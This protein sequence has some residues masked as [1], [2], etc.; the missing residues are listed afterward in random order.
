MRVIGRRQR[1]SRLILRF[2]DDDNDQ[3]H[4]ISF[5][6]ENS[7]YFLSGMSSGNLR[8]YS[9]YGKKELTLAYNSKDRLTLA[10]KGGLTTTSVKLYKDG[11]LYHTFGD[12][13]VVFINET[14]VYQAIA[15]D[16]YYSNEVTVTAVTETEAQL[17][18]STRTCFLL[19]KDGKV[20]YW[21][22][23][24]SGS[25][26]M[27]NNTT[28]NVPTLHDNLNAL[29]S[30]IKQIGSRTDSYPKCAITN[31]G[32]LYTWGYNTDGALGRGNESDY[33]SQGPWLVSTQSSNTF[34]RCGVGYY[35]N[36]ALQDNGYLWSCGNNSRYELGD[37]TNTDRNTFIRVDLANVIDFQGEHNGCIA[38]TSTS[39]VYM[40]GTQGE[41]YMSDLG[42][43]A[44]PTELTSLIGKNIVKVRS[45]ANTGYA[46]SS[47]GK[48]YAWGNG[49][50]YELPSGTTDDITT[51]TEMTWFSRNNVKVVDVV[52][53][54]GPNTAYLALDDQDRMYV[55]GQDGNGTIGD[56]SGDVTSYSVPF[57]LKENIS[58]M[59][60][61][62]H[63][64]GC[65]DKFG[66]V[67]TW[68]QANAGQQNWIYGADSDTNIELPTS[69]NLSVGSSVVYDG[70]DK[71]VFGKGSTTTSNVTYGSNT[72]SLGTNSEVF[73]AE[74]HT[75]KFKIMDTDSVTYTSNV[76]ST[77]PA[78]PTGRVYPPKS[79]T[80]KDLSLTASAN[81]DNTWTIDGALYG[82]GAYKASMSQTA[83]H[84]NQ[85]PY[86][87]FTGTIDYSSAHTQNNVQT[88]DFQIHMP[89][90]IKLTKYAI[91]SRNYTG[92]KDQAPKDWKVYG[93][94]DNGTTWTELDSQT[95]QTVTTW[96]DELDFLDTKREYT[97]TGNTKYFSS[98]KFDVTA[99]NGN[100]YL[101]ISQIEY[102]GD[103]EGFLT[104]DGFGKLTLD[105]KGDTNATSN[106]TFHSNTYV[107][108]AA[109]DLYIKDTGE[110]SANIYGSS[111]A[112]LGEKVYT[113][114]TQDLA[115]KFTAAFHHG[116]FSA[117]D[118]S[119][120]YSSVGRQQQRRVS[121]IPIHPRG[122]IRGER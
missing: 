3:G 80:H 120:A 54:N 71:Y 2:N 101:V 6:G 7:E 104:D 38:V 29:P 69:N 14:G 105:V 22:D 94:N 25:N 11:T 112:F 61:G 10:Y 115:P 53:G 33:T 113:V 103:D 85:C 87:A 55:W 24:S 47:D 82:N 76:V 21:G 58:S 92:D 88:S 65:I 30:G 91:Y 67:Y 15:D 4:D 121:C 27:G 86:R 62:K 41:S 79:G 5:C 97:V 78:R 50:N 42:T 74:P 66:Q 64:A 36:Y 63:A 37:G 39:N 48:L 114:G 59:A 45:S 56:G 81:T 83:N 100:A 57:L 34:T 8:M 98:Y 70:F 72:V 90:K 95:N 20:W 17:C 52:P 109:R 99:N 28:V 16:T 96:G 102:Y 122:R 89:Q 119:S 107:M 110:Y 106:I 75:Y 31:D 68:G 9:W 118:Y 32:K 51:P 84:L 93:S 108:G 12:E 73:L 19:K 60:S 35:C 13:T 46:I 43:Q 49:G 26:G 40:W 77:T 116:P 23:S 1:T 44:S 111:K 117:S 18:M